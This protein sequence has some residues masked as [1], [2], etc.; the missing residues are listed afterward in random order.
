LK[1][2]RREELETRLREVGFTRALLRQYA[3]SLVD[4]GDPRGEWILCDLELRERGKIASESARLLRR[5]TEIIEQ[6][7]G[8]T[9]FAW[10]RSTAD[11]ELGFVHDVF[12][13]GTDEQAVAAERDLLAC[14]VGACI[15]SVMIRGT[16]EHMRNLVSLLARSTRPW[17]VQLQFEPPVGQLGTLFDEVT[18]ASLIAATPRLTKLIV[19]GTDHPPSPVFAAF[20]HPNRPA[21]DRYRR[22]PPSALDD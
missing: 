15:R 17:L 11:I 8:S 20:A 14:P 19:T 7:V 1:V 10:F 9:A 18:T 12:L 6:L 5:R 3:A 21:I 22:P 13:G 4:H 16:A 2:T